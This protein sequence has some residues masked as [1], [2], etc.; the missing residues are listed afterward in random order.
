MYTHTTLVK[1]KLKT[2]VFW[3]IITNVN[4]KEYFLKEF[5]Y[6][7]GKAKWVMSYHNAL[8]FNSGT[9]ARDYVKKFLGRRKVQCISLEI[10]LT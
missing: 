9:L 4:G 2:R 7:N 8:K 1:K 3:F 10:K 6:K 5:S